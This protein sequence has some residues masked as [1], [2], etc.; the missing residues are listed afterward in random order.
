MADLAPD[1]ASAST[2][3]R[4]HPRID[5]L[6]TVGLWFA[7]FLPLF[8]VFL[9]TATVDEDRLSPDPVAA[10]MP[11]WRLANHGD[12]T[13]DGHG[14]NNVWVGEAQGR[15]VSNRQPGVILVGVPFYAV[16][17]R[18]PFLISMFPAA[19]AAS[20]VTAAA[21][22]CLML[23]FRRLVDP[24]AALVATAIVAFG[25]STW[26][27][28]ADALWAHGPDQLFLAAGTAMLAGEHF[29]GTGIGYGLA[30][31]TRT[32]LAVAA[33]V[34][35]IWHSVV[36]RSPWP[37][38][39][40]GIP[41]ISAVAGVMLY[42]HHVFGGWNLHA[43]FAG[44]FPVVPSLES[45]GAGSLVE[46]IAGFFISPDRGLLVISPF[47]LILAPGLGAAWR[48]APHWARSSAVAGG[49]YLLGQARIN[50]FSGGD[51]F[52]GYRLSLET[53]T[54]AAPLLLL[55]WRE[56]VRP[57]AWRRAAFAA[58]VAVSVGVQVIGATL[59]DS[60]SFHWSAWTH[61]WL[62]DVLRESPYRGT[63]QV[64]AGL[65]VVAAVVAAA[66]AARPNG[67]FKPERTP[68]D[69]PG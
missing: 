47:L 56:W 61:S 23:V 8:V 53:L 1:E 69:A 5:R 59:F 30:I 46:N 45:Q 34:V 13:L 15:R 12:L 18:D 22:A 37:A 52:W 20:A 33:A 17:A 43:G 16:M 26:S 35:G 67:P 14:Y 11:A 58:A 19:V 7:V 36:R 27:V 4:P 10:A 49:G 21:M 57:V 63:A 2:D 40:V 48:S 50:Y 25:T 55:S 31:L 3:R 64:I 60:P 68:A 62:W 42:V 41:T 39:A 44:P 9:A 54:L 24:R 32:H 6:G 28:S 29:A 38:V 65:T 66:L 51:R